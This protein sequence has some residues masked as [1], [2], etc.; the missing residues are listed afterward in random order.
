MMGLGW[1]FVTEM[2]AGALLGWGIGAWLGDET[3]G[4]MIGTLVGFAIATYSLIRGAIKLNAALDKLDRAS[5]RR[6]PPPLANPR[7][8]KET[9]RDN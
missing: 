3:T 9:P 1:Q 7:D 6:P 5:G 4:T 8:Q 2:L